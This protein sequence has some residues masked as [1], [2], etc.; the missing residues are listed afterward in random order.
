M[1]NSATYPPFQQAIGSPVTALPFDDQID[2][3]MEWASA[4][5]SKV[6]CVA[7]VHMLVEA[8]R[9]PAF[10]AILKQADLVTPD[11]MPLVW[12]LKLLGVA[13]QNRVAGFDVVMALCDRATQQRVG[14]FFL[15]S[16]PAILDKMRVRLDREFPNLPI[17]GMEPLPFRPLT[18][19]EDEAIVRQINDS[20]A[21]IVLLSLGCPKQEIWM[22]E[23]RDRIQAVMLGVGGVFPVYAGNQKLAPEYIRKLGLEWMYRLIQEPRRL[24]WR[25]ASTNP[26]FVWLAIEQLATNWWQQNFD[27]QQSNG[28]KGGR[29]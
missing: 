22:N 6:I 5:A 26:V 7:N 21:G 28:M 27:R 20:G 18:P 11:G 4:R 2:L 16:E 15:G 10:G 14:V 1:I 24:F 12:L 17:A 3:M 8:H 25:Y 29:N 9:K 13:N 23:H 19:A